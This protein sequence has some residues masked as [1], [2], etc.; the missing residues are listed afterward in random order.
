MSALLESLS[1]NWRKVKDKVSGQLSAGKD[2]MKEAH[3]S[4][5]RCSLQEKTRVLGLIAA[6]QM[7]SGLLQQEWC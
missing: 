7:S 3:L 2:L 5:T 1:A 6:M 4:G